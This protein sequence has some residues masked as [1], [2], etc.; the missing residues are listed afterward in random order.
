MPSATEVLHLQNDGLSSDGGTL[1]EQGTSNSAT[2]AMTS[3][4]GTDEEMD[5]AEDSVEELEDEEDTES[6]YLANQYPEM[7]S[8]YMTEMPYYAPDHDM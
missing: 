8:L 3:A 4:Q 2:T 5:M 1:S 6:V 7:S